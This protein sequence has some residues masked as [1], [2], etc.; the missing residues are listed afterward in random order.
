MVPLNHCQCPSQGHCA[1][2]DKA[3]ASLPTGSACP[4]AIVFALTWVPCLGGWGPQLLEGLDSISAP[5]QVEQK[6]SLQGRPCHCFRGASPQAQGSGWGSAWF[7][8]WWGSFRPR[9]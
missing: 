1:Q 8:Q 7:L 5:P 2:G 4:K 6:Q 9:D 3:W